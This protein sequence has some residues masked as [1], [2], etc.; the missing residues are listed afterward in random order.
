LPRR[1]DGQ[2]VYH[3]TADLE[4]ASGDTLVLVGKGGAAAAVGELQPQTEG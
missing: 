2:A 3:P 4:L 1:A